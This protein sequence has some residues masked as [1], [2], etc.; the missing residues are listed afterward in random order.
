MHVRQWGKRGARAAPTVR[1]TSAIALPSSHSSRRPSCGQQG[2]S[3]KEALADAY[4]AID[5]YRKS[6]QMLASMKL[7]STQKSITADEK[8]RVWIRIVQCYLEE[9]DPTSAFSHLNKVKS[10]IY[11]VNDKEMRMHFQLSQA[12]VYDGQPLLPRRSSRILRNEP[13]ASHSVERCWL[14]YTRMN[15]PARLTATYPR[16]DLSRPPSLMCRDQ[17]LR[18]QTTTPPARKNRRRVHCSQQGCSR[19][20]SAGCIE[21]VQQHQLD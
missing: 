7:E 6:V 21:A 4:E 14:S 5:D 16:K 11:S 1:S 15:E 17:D 2:T 18:Y 9:H 3:I 12:R 10:I 19:A 20:Q 13:P 8:A